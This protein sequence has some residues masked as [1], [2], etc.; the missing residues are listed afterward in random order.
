MIRSFRCRETERV[1]YDQP[2]RAFPPDIIRSAK[3]KLQY[4][5]AAQVVDDKRGR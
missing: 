4:L 2:T 5:D 1:F 3:R